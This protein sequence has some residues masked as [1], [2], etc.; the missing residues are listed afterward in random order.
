[1]LF[2]DRSECSRRKASSP[3]NA[4]AAAAAAT[5][6]TTTGL[7][8]T[9]PVDDR[10]LNNPYVD[11]VRLLPLDNHAHD[12]VDTAVQLDDLRGLEFLSE[13]KT[14]LIFRATWKG[15]RV[16]IKMLHGN[17]LHDEVARADFEHERQ[18]LLRVRHP[19]IVQLLGCG[20]TY[21]LPLLDH[22]APP[23]VAPPTPA[24]TSPHSPAPPPQHPVTPTMH[25][26]HDSGG[27]GCSGSGGDGASR[28]SSLADDGSEELSQPFLVLEHLVHLPRLLDLR[29]QTHADVDAAE[30]CPFSYSDL[31][32]VA[33]DVAAAMDYLH[34]GWHPKV[35]PC[36]GP[37]R[38]PPLPLS[39]HPRTSHLPLH[40]TYPP[41]H[42]PTS[43]PQ[44]MIVFRDL[45]PDNVGMTASGEV[46]LFDLALAVCVHKRQSLSEAYEMT[47]C[48]GSIR[49]MAP[50]VSLDMPY[51]EK[52]DVYSYALV[53]WACAFSR[54]VSEPCF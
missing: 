29:N 42:L 20:V 24:S 27:G 32:K 16:I 33:A 10:S 3:R 50:E 5:T 13:G 4:T 26:G 21:S 31:L 17:V 22:D 45:K 40:P 47:G 19:N 39:A 9:C 14:T 37:V 46:K 25:A 52:V 54:C 44:A 1:M 8:L 51:S 53:L 12:H 48:T 38:G 36:G 2:D 41:P 18:L 30:H 34:D 7:S 35:Q 28:R 49:Y 43:P 15:Q 11:Y 6:T 23:P